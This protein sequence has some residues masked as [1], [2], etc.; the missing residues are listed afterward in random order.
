MIA[1]GE[2]YLE[3]IG[4]KGYVGHL[5]CTPLD[6]VAIEFCSAESQQIERRDAVTSHET[7]KSQ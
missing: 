1:V 2:R 3:A 6:V 4:D 7:V 5:G